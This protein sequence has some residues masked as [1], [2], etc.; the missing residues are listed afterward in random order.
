MKKKLN[1]IWLEGAEIILAK[2]HRNKITSAEGI[3]ATGWVP[4]DLDGLRAE[5][6]EW[7][8]AGKQ[9][10]RMVPHEK[11]V[12]QLTKS[13]GAE[14]TQAHSGF[15]SISGGF[16]LARNGGVAAGGGITIVQWVEEGESNWKG[17]SPR[18]KGLDLSREIGKSRG[19]AV[20]PRPSG[21]HSMLGSRSV[22]AWRTW[23]TW[24][25]VGALLYA[26]WHCLSVFHMHVG[27]A[28]LLKLKKMFF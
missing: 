24:S 4:W 10:L 2:E 26:L 12:V 9:P 25:L 8:A 23:R 19:G 27:F 21:A 11:P 18:G 7:S 13:K 14:Q 6:E 3:S 22:E 20:W 17:S 5:K 16:C 28:A 1:Y 15:S